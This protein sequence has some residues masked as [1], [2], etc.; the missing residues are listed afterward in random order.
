MDY[1]GR[2]RWREKELLL[3]GVHSCGA[4]K[5]GWPGELCGQ[6]LRHASLEVSPTGP[7][8]SDSLRPSVCCWTLALLSR[9]PKRVKELKVYQVFVWDYILL[10]LRGKKSM[11]AVGIYYICPP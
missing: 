7:L 9:N 8:I 2:L 1:R 5:Q 10:Y 4:G 3:P 6:S 11:P